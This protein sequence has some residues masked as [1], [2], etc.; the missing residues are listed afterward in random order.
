MALVACMNLVVHCH[1][2]PHGPNDTGGPGSPGC[3][4]G[5][6]GSGDP[7]GCGSPDGPGGPES[8]DSNMINAESAQFTWSSVI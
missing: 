6:G 3:P 8:P 2:G 4:H 1:G 7:D 5:P